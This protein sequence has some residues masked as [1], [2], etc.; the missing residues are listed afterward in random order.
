MKF[1]FNLFSEIRKLQVNINENPKKNM[2]SDVFCTH[3]TSF[4]TNIVE[5]EMC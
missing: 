1:L 3:K 5:A 2:Y 4:T